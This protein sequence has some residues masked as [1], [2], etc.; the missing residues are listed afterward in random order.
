[1]C[2]FR[3]APLNQ[4]CGA[5]LNNPLA[6]YSASLQL[7]AVGHGTSD[8]AFQAKHGDPP[9]TPNYMALCY[10]LKAVWNHCEEKEPWLGL[11]VP[12]SK[13]PKCARFNLVEWQEA[14]VQRTLRTEPVYW[15]SFPLSMSN[16]IYG[17]SGSFI[18][19]YVVSLCNGCVGNCAHFP[20]DYI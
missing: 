4:S 8:S 1:M 14:W 10:V 16:K 15:V 18:L 19:S 13:P 20:L 9:N 2:F 11:I 17:V 6:I 3:T 12:P 7:Q 5:L